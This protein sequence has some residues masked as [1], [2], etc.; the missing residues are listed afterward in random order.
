MTTDYSKGKVYKIFNDVDT[1]F[2]VGSTVKSL[3]KRKAQH[4][5][6]AEVAP[7][8]KIYK[9]LQA[10]GWDN[11][12]IELIENYPCVSK[13]ELLEREK[14]YIE[15]LKPSLNSVRVVLTEEE[16]EEERQKQFVKLNEY[17]KANPEI[18]KASD[19]KSYEKR[20]EVILEQHKQYYESNKELKQQQQRDYYALNK[21]KIRAESKKRV[22]CPNCHK[23]MS[24]ASLSRHI[25]TSCKSH[26]G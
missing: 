21:E 4:K 18:K 9:H 10:I 8:R 1:E 11:V 19:K 14:Y 25:S 5:K 26:Q 3:P 24:Q 22:S 17:M 7:D 20:R 15:L 6:K 2:Y 13:A 16:K 23:E 12:K